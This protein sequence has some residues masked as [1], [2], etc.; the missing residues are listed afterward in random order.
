MGGSG[1]GGDSLEGGGGA[2]GVGGAAVGANGAT[3]AG[4]TTFAASTAN[5]SV[6]ITASGAAV[7]A[8]VERSRDSADQD[9]GGDTGQATTRL[10]LPESNLNSR[11]DSD[12]S[13]KKKQRKYGKFLTDKVSVWET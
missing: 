5:S 6:T 12:R 2:G 9:G 3:L 11:Q 7:H 8:D 4:A 13:L 10:L 1:G